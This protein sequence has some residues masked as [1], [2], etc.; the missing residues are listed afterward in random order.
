LTHKMSEI[1]R[2]HIR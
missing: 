1:A 2:M